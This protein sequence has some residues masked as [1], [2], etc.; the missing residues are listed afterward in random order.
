[1]ISL[2]KQIKAC[3]FSGKPFKECALFL[4]VWSEILEIFV[5][6]ENIPE[7]E[8]TTDELVQKTDDLKLD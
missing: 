5:E 8:K 2:D 1:M 4:N 6:L 7:I 3:C